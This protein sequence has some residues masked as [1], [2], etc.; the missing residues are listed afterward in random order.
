ML[1]ALW[2]WF[3]GMGK[4]LALGLLLLGLFMAVAGYFAV[5]GAWR[6]YVVLAWKKR[7]RNRGAR[8]LPSRAQTQAR[9]ITARAPPHTIS[10]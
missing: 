5:R 6:L 7:A 1:P 4:P 8:S 2:D 10:A 9:P 3:S